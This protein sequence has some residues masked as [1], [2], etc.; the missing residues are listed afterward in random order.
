M[1]SR[2][3]VDVLAVATAGGAALCIASAVF[4]AASVSCS[5]KW[6]DCAKVEYTETWTCPQ[7][8]HCCKDVYMS[9]GPDGVKNTADDC[10]TDVNGSC[11]ASDGNCTR[12][13]WNKES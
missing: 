12:Y 4:A 3:I 10:V 5:S 8:S 11:D 9:T 2:K 7:N 1:I 13:H 6:T